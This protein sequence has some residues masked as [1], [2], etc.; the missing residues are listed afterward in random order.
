MLICSS[1]AARD[2]AAFKHALSR[3][4]AGLEPFCTAYATA[5]F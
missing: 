4:A 3:I 2:V 1:V 5:T